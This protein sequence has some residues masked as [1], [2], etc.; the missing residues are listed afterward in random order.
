MDAEGASLSIFSQCYVM[1]F[2]A[3]VVNTEDLPHEV[4]ADCM[5]AQISND[6]RGIWRIVESLRNVKFGIG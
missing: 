5:V 4:D 2:Q 3:L 6:D 1:A